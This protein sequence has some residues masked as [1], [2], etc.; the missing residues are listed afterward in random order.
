MTAVCLRPRDGSRFA[1][2]TRQP[3][4]RIERSIVNARA[5]TVATVGVA[6]VAVALPSGAQARTKTVAMGAP[7]QKV[8]NRFQKLGT[9]VNDF[10]PH[11]VAIH[12][13]D[14]V[15]FVPTEFH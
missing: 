13:G 4:A 8:S 9:E 1:S 3:G 14:K 11:G 15:R 7:T 6:C 12:T 10:F 2:S 5:R